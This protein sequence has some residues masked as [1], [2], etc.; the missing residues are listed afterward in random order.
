MQNNFLQ[1]IHW[2]IF[3]ELP[4]GLRYSC[5][6]IN[7]NLENLLLSNAVPRYY[8]QFTYA[9]IPSHG[10]IYPKYQD[11]WQVVFRQGSALHPLIPPLC[12]P[13][14]SEMLY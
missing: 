1:G 12:V 9:S 14:I 6:S 3:I 5:S 8:I 7:S 13:P 4:T 2:H 11:W 10:L